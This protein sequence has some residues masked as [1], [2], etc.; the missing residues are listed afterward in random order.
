LTAAD[1]RRRPLPA[2]AASAV[3]AFAVSGVLLARS[4]AFQP[5]VPGAGATL[6]ALAVTLAAAVIGGLAARRLADAVR[7]A[8]P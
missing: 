7:D 8:A 3:A 4:P 6:V 1:A 2:T 5:M